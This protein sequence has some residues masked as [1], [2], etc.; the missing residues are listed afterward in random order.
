MWDAYPS[1]VCEI[2]QGD[3][4][5]R[6][7]ALGVYYLGESDATML[8]QL[9]S[10]ADDLA[11]GASRY[12]LLNLLPPGGARCAAD[13]ALWDLEAQLSSKSAWQAAGVEAN[14]VET[15]FTIGLEAEPADMAAKAAAAPDYNL[16][17]IKL[18]D[19]RPV[20]RVAAIREV[21]PDAR[22]IVDINGGWTFEQ[23]QRFSPELHQLG[24]EMIEQPLPRGEDS[25][26]EGYLCP[27]PLCADESC[28]HL[29]ELEQAANRYQFINIK[30]DKTGGLTHGLQLAHAAKA[31]DLGI[32]VGS[33]CGS[34]LAMAPHHVVA[35]LAEYADIDGPLLMKNDRIGGLVYD[36]GFVSL[37]DTRFWG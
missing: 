5:G 20:E 3:C 21:R 6:G 16:L 26:L 13:A 25:E 31:R 15:D 4:V 27:V 23:L 2:R 12:D 30:L 29:G 36:R 28:L 22:L 7:E 1:V 19:D 37:P 14:P 18:N 24:V 8:A 34:S 9:E 17:K 32:M 33:M 10:I 11:A 35:Q